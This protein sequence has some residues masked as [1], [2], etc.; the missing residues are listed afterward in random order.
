MNEKLD[1]TM[2]IFRDYEKRFAA[3][4]LDISEDFF[5]DEK[6]R[7]D[8]LKRVKKMLKISEE[9]IPTPHD[10]EELSSS[11][12]NGYTISE[13]RYK[14]YENCYSYLTLTMPKGKGKVPLV[15]LF[16]GHTKNGRKAKNN[17]ILHH[18]LAKMGIAV[19]S[20]DNIGQGDRAFM[21]HNFSH[22]PFYCGLTLQGLI[23][24]ESLGIIRYMKN[25]PRIDPERM[26]AV[27][28]SG[29]GTLTMFL[30]ALSTELSAIAS[31]GYP[32]EFSYVLSKERRHCACNLLPGSAY[33]GMWELYGLFSPRPLLL[34]QGKYDDLIPVDLFYRNARKVSAVYSFAG[35]GDNFSS[36]VTETRHPHGE[37]DRILIAR[38]FA[39]VFGVKERE[40]SEEDF[41]VSEPGNVVTPEN[42]VNTK[43]LAEMLSG[44]KTPEK[45]NLSDIFK[46][47]YKGKT[48]SEEDYL[49]DIG[50]G[51]LKTVFAQME[52]ALNKEW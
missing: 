23:V 1:L 13:I 38:F 34:E 26:G 29:G 8:L 5:F 28:N 52:C 41:E 48:L 15:F 36:A 16:N 42:A 22:E 6:R 7:E 37:E 31:C 25:H 47:S 35:A 44:I 40:F 21:G 18:R 19:L 46:P 39:S 3:A 43:E 4:S 33:F 20:P 30:A 11:G 10:F 14:T 50:R 45:V 9:L 2:K 17:L 32:S 12:Y 51:S 24:A 49:E 27:G